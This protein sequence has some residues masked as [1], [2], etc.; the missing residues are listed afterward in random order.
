MIR[1]FIFISHHLALD[2]AQSGSS[3]EFQ[4]CLHIETAEPRPCSTL[5]IC[6]ISLALRTYID[7][8]ITATLRRKRAQSLRGQEFTCTDIEHFLLL[9][10]R[11]RRIVESDWENH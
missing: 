1:H 11:K 2:E 6:I 7:R 3:V 10:L 9:A 8:I 4:T 5:M